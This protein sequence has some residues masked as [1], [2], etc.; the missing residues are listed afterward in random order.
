MMPTTR[1]AVTTFASLI[2]AAFPFGGASASSTPSVAPFLSQVK[3][4]WN[5]GQ[6][7]PALD[8]DGR[9][10]F[11]AVSV[12]EGDKLVG[13]ADERTVVFLDQAP[14][15]NAG[16]GAVRQRIVVLNAKPATGEGLEYALHGVDPTLAE[17][18]AG[19]CAKPEAERVIP[20]EAIASY[21][22]SLYFQDQGE[23]RF[24]GTTPDGCPI[25]MRGATRMMSVIELDGPKGSMAFEHTGLDFAGQTRWQDGQAYLRSEQ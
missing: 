2:L 11:C 22:C 4:T 8:D 18:L 16:V 5:M 10:T 23:G 14:P 20:F 19:L 24:R 21:K 25:F 3:G 7:T 15:A 9:L 12:K 13:P 17:S 1:T 6:G